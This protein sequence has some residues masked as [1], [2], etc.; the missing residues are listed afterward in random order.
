MQQQARYEARSHASD[1]QER[2]SQQRPSR[3]SLRQVPLTDQ[4]KI[5][6]IMQAG[7]FRGNGSP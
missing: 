4:G 1:H 5:S 6:Q 2:Q 7:P 3:M